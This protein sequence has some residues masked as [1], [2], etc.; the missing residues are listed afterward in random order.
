MAPLD[1]KSYDWQQRAARC[2]RLSNLL[3]ADETAG[4]LHSL[5]LAMEQRLNT[6]RQTRAVTQERMLDNAI[7]LAQ[8]D[9]FLARARGAMFFASQLLR[10]LRLKPDDLREESR[11]CREEAEEAEDAAARR[12]FAARALALAVLGEEI[13]MERTGPAL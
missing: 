1:E 11:L 12:A 7:L 3:G 9:T 8:I 2:R 6:F 5:A 10:P 13:D 4:R